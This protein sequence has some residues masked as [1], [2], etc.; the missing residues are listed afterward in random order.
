M[1]ST[2]TLYAGRA[3]LIEMI[4]R[5]RDNLLRQPMYDA[6]ALV[7]P[8]SGTITITDATNTA[9]VSAAAV[10]IASS[11]ARYTLLAAVVPSTLQLGEGWR[12]E[13][14][15]VM[16]DGTTRLVRR[17]A[18]LVR[19]RLLPP[20]TWAD[21]FRREP[22]LDPSTAHPIHSLTLA[23]L[24]PFLDEAWVQIEG[25]LL[26]AGRR[27]WLV[28]SPQA[29]R[30]VLIVGTLT[31]LYRYFA[32]RLKPAYAEIADMYARQYETEW[33]RIRLAYD[34]DDDGQA[35]GGAV[36]HRVGPSGSVWLGSQRGPVPVWRS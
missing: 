34:A 20:A 27:P 16:P 17:D 11:E 23:Q 28:I 26:A 10:T 6:G 36:P 1:A 5:A 21:V 24:D 32:T 2:D 8:S 13:W 3:E 14:S 29:L 12:I 31:Y 9:I 15:L 35:D 4:E 19:T 7:A 33:S 30:E 18:A 22:G 25:R